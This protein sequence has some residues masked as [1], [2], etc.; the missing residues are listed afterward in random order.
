VAKFSSDEVKALDEVAE[1]GEAGT[2]VTLKLEGTCD[3]EAF[4]GTDDVKVINV[5]GK[6]K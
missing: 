1:A 5:T 4:I 3:G 6:K 2:L